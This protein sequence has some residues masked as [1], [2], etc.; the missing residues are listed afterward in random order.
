MTYHVSSGT[1]SPYTTTTRGRSGSQ[2]SWLRKLHSR[3]HRL[4]STVVSVVTELLRYRAST[5]VACPASI[6]AALGARSK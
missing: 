4:A 6:L 2:W 5:T 1:L 3:P